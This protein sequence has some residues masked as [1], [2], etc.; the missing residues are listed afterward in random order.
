MNAE[1]LAKKLHESF[2]RVTPKFY[3]YAEGKRPS[4]EELSEQ[5]QK[6]LIAV[7]ADVLGEEVKIEAQPDLKPVPTKE[8][9]EEARRN[10]PTDEPDNGL[11]DWEADL[12]RQ[13]DDT[14][15]QA[16]NPPKPFDGIVR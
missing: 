4:W 5:S 11:S 12:R 7:C 16:R 13:I 10:A 9:F 3:G 14:V 8:E 1:E 2:G 6:H 15:K